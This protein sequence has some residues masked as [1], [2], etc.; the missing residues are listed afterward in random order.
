MIQ[1]RL[2]FP[3]DQKLM[4]AHIDDIGVCHSANHASFRALNMGIA[5]SGSLMMTCPWISEVAR[6][7]RDNPKWDLGIHA[8]FNS[9]RDNYRWR[10]IASSDRVS[11]L[12]DSEG[13]FYRD[14]EDVMKKGK[15]EEVKLELRT[16][17]ERAH[18]LGFEPTHLDAHMFTC[19]RRTDTFEV[20]L[21]LAK[22]YGLVPLLIRPTSP[23]LANWFQAEGEEWLTP[24]VDRLE[25]E[26]FILVD[27]ILTS[28][29]GP[30]GMPLSIE[31]RRDTYQRLIRE[32]V[33]GLNY[34]TLH[35]A[36]YD[37]ETRTAMGERPAESRSLDH[38]VFMEEETG[39]VAENA[40][41][42][43]IGWRE[44]QKVFKENIGY[45][46]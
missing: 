3:A 22:E 39:R 11:S 44:I 2:G 37:Y 28:R 33:P 34:L 17:I 29:I 20:Y 14:P 30:K 40:G 19:L 38:Q 12:I 36:H 5:K 32:C 41:V 18:Q 21:S 31:D 10:P 35:M 4:I 42:K 16:Q 45:S 27:C 8:T 15:A 9:E 24:D 25:S 26:G 13:Y 46:G 23:G 43:L 6:S 1:E 7:F